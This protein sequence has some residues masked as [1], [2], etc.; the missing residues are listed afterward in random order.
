MQGPTQDVRSCFTVFDKIDDEFREK[1]LS[2]GLGNTVGNI[3]EM[4]RKITRVE[5]GVDLYRKDSGFFSKIN[6]VYLKKTEVPYYYQQTMDK[7]K[8]LI[9]DNLETAME[10]KAELS[11]GFMTKNRLDLLDKF[12]SVANSFLQGNLC[13]PEMRASSMQMQSNSANFIKYY[14]KKLYDIAST[15]NAGT[16]TS[17]NPNTLGA[18]NDVTNLFAKVKNIY[19]TYKYKETEEDKKDFIESVQKMYNNNIK[20]AKDHL[21]TLNF[22]NNRIKLLNE[23]TKVAEDCINNVPPPSQGGAA[24]RRRKASRRYKKTGGKKRGSRRTRCRR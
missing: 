14:S 2:I 20:Y 18:F 19:E 22:A 9:R 3:K 15:I 24:R 13:S 10:R 17:W 12:I 5:D 4:L 1:N 7:M 8:E 16:S 6:D 23:F 11:K 21:E